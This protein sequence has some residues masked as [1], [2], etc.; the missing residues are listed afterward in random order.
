VKASLFHNSAALVLIALA[1]GS[2]LMGQQYSRAHANPPVYDLLI[3]NAR[4][5]DGSGNP[6]FRADVAVSQAN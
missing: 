3:T 1:L 6:W 5:V 2:L 4:I